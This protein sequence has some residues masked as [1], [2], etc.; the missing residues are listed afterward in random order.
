MSDA[1][2][3][4]MTT[5]PDK[6]AKPGWFCGVATDLSRRF[7]FLMFLLFVVITFCLCYS[8][9][10][11]I[12]WGDDL[13]GAFNFAVF[14]APAAL[15]IVLLGVVPGISLAFLT[16]IFVFMRAQ[17][18][19]TSVYDFHLADPLMSVISITVGAILMAA[20]VTPA[21]R[22]WPAD[23]SRSTERYK[24]LN[25]PRIASILIGC[26]L[27]TI[28][29]S[30]GTRGLIY[31]IITPGG[32][33]YGY[34]EMIANYLASLQSPLVPLEAAVNGI[35][36]SVS[37]YLLV[38][39]NANRRAGTWRT[40][41]TAT[42]TRWLAFVMLIM[43]VVSSSWSFC[44]ETLSATDEAEK[45]ITAELEYLNKQVDARIAS[46]SSVKEVANGYSTALGGTVVIVRNHEV[47]SSNNPELVGKPANEVMS[48]SYIDNYDYLVDLATEEMITGMD[49][50]IMEFIGV[51]A[52]VGN[53]FTIINTAPLRAMY[54]SRT[55]TLMYNAAF[56]LAMLVVVFVVLRLM[57]RRIVVA[58]IHRTNDTLALITKGELQQRVNERTVEEFD[59]LSTGINTT[60]VALKDMMDEVE[61]R[62]AQDL[63]AAKAIQE[64]VLPRTFPPFPDIDRFDIYASLK[65]AR[66]VGGDFYDF[67][68]IGGDKLGFLIAD[69]SGKG[70]PASLFMMTAKT[71]IKSYM[72]TGAPVNEAIDAANHQLCLGND[73]GMFVTVFAC[74]LDLQTGL[75]SYVNAGH[76]PPLLNHDGK[77]EWMRDVSGM[78]LGLF[79]GLPYERFSQQIEPTDTLY[80]YTDGVTE[81]MDVDGALFGEDRL[82][83]TLECFAGMNARSISVGVRRALTDFT[84]DA[85]QSDDITMLTLRYGVPP[86]KNAI[87][88]LPA[89]VKQLIHVYNFIH[90]ELKRRNAPKSVYGPLDIAAEELFVN[91]CH[92]AYPDS[93]AEDPGEVR[94]GFEY[95][96]NPPSLTVTISDDG[97]PYDP[98]AK[99][100]AVTP[101]NIAD[102]PIGGLGILMAKRSVDDMFYERV[103][104]SNV[105]T[106]RKEW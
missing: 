34:A 38:L 82:L 45:Q 14:I 50:A 39:Q 74:V 16:G 3:T 21:A 77:W 95:E 23:L 104:N 83:K 2:K 12:A 81:A 100:D 64:S 11:I 62:N 106:F 25:I 86:E 58:P 48:S 80:L 37:C 4:A 105:V 93:A 40:N 47:I 29:Y 92:Y 71:Q 76:N 49:D 61:H 18:T 9:F 75:L 41:I 31:L 51:R 19:P 87:M 33:E 66:G 94:I 43:F 69:V 98:L 85:E 36:I 60:V 7:R 97:V 52:L 88:V 57:L 96:A 6:N 54:K 13:S 27:Y 28:A 73:A 5:K 91:V 26:F 103:G 70:I 17:W 32:A 20:V 22:R 68:L 89:D 35:L 1:P 30:F 72:E 67:F 24:R 8:Q 79:D 59:E 78:P 42:F 56:L 99:P 53:H 65:M 46:N 63:V 15:C 101:D 44:A 90:E 84:L 10:G 102:V 55:A